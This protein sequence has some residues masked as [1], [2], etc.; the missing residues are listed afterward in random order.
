MKRG[1]LSYGDSTSFQFVRKQCIRPIEAV[2]AQLYV[3]NF[4]KLP[5][6]TQNNEFE[7]EYQ[8]HNLFY[9]IV[10]CRV[11]KDGSW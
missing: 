10:C 5:Y 1:N 4:N 3:G 2:S 9:C 7:A 8:F 11:T 6:F